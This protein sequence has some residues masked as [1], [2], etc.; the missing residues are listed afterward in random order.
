MALR[1]RTDERSTQAS[2]APRMLIVSGSGPGAFH[3]WEVSAMLDDC[4]PT[5]ARPGPSSQ[6]LG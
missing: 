6:E 5:A 3:S 2:N 1:G 4:P